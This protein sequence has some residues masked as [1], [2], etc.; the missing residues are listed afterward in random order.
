M[1]EFTSAGSFYERGRAH[2]QRFG[3]LLPEHIDTVC[4]CD[5][6]W[7]GQIDGLLGQIERNLARC[8]PHQLEE[9]RGMAAGSG[10]E[11]D[12]LLRLSYWPEVTLCTMGL[13]FCSLAAFTDVAGGP[14]LGK[15]S[16]HPINSLRFFAIER[17]HNE[18]PLHSYVRGTFLGTNGT[19]AGLNDAGLA[20]CG[21]AI[22]ARGR[23]PEGLPVMVLIQSILEQCSNVDQAVELARGM[24][25]F[26]YGGHVM[27]G[28]AIGHAATIERLPNVMAVRRPAEGTL[29]NTNH[30]L[31]PDTA[32][33][34]AAEPALNENS[35]AR[36]ER[37]RCL[38]RDAPRTAAGMQA[39]LRDHTQPGAI[40]QHG[41][42]DLHTTGAYVLLP[43]ERQ[44]WV[45]PGC[46]CL[47][48]FVP[49]Q[50]A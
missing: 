34:N 5:V 13:R 40:C 49:L 39:I 47:H 46:P 17:V 38:L 26:S 7:S 18:A 22:A 32:A 28:D 36:Y 10:V 24:P 31:A 33:E 3:Q 43:A 19:R 8:V 16:D 29:A 42:A 9:L 30:P 21:A 25:T 44:M 35:H 15:T 2:G 1:I 12:E 48:A 23:N 11:L 50:V 4:R 45:A 6:R 27:V 20:A 37:L 14:I 41:P